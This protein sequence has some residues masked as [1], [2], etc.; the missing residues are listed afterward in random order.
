MT[1]VAAYN[2]TSY[3][4]MSTGRFYEEIQVA[5]HIELEQMPFAIEKL[6]Y[7]ASGV[8]FTYPTDYFSAPPMVRVSIELKNLTYS[9]S[10]ILTFCVTSNTASQTTVRV[11]KG[12]LSGI[13]EAATDDVT[14]HL[15]AVG[16][17]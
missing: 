16:H 14:V 13:M 15:F 10:D 5:S 17:P 2:F 11:N 6:D 3:A 7:T 12:N 9:S 4:T 1:F 8:T